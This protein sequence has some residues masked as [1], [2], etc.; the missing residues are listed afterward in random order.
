MKKKTKG[1]RAEKELQ[2]KPKVWKRPRK[3]RYL[4]KRA[5]KTVIN[6]GLWK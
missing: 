5:G 3:D 6:C 4:K 2:T 1:N